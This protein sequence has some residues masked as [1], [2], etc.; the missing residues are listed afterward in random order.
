MTT[1]IHGGVL[2]L[3]PL[4]LRRF[5][6][7]RNTWYN[8]VYV[9]TN[10]FCAIFHYWSITSNLLFCL[11]NITKASQQHNCV[12]SRS[13]SRQVTGLRN[14]RTFAL[15][16]GLAGR[17]ISC[18]WVILI[19]FGLRPSRE[20]VWHLSTQAN[21][22]IIAVYITVLTQWGVIIGASSPSSQH[23]GLSEYC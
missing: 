8:Y 11:L 1:V 17:F 23:Y 4:F 19:G 6:S 16:N 12:F 15:A 22:S 10:P 9:F 21:N 3:L 20:I 5:S 14:W 18:Y 13:I 7:S 2:L